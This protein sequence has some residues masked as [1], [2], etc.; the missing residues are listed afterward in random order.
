MGFSV[1]RVVLTVLRAVCD[2]LREVRD[3]LLRV[4]LDEV[5]CAVFDVL[6]T[7]F[8]VLCADFAERLFADAP[9]RCVRVVPVDCDVV[10]LVCFVD[11][12]CLDCVS[13]D[14]LVR[15]G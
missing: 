11:A 1:F 3:V 15:R 9:E 8:A 5:P 6:C 7:A 4:V 13:F 2:V 14:E 12:W 10:R